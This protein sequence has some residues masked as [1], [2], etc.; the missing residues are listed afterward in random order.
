[1]GIRGILSAVLCVVLV[2]SSVMFLGSMKAQGPSTATVFTDP[3]TIQTTDLEETFIVNLNVSNVVDLYGWQAGITFNPEVL[4]CTGFFEGEFLK[5]SEQMTLFL[6]HYKDMNNTLGIVYYRGDTILGPVPGVNGSGQLAYATFRSK[7][8]GVSD[9][10]LTD[11]ILI[12]SHV[13]QILFE[14]KES[15]TVF[16]S[17]TNYDVAIVDNLT[18]QGSPAN[19]PLSGMFS[20]AFNASEKEVHFSAVSVG[21]WF[22]E[23]N[24]PKTLLSS[25][26]SSAWTVKVDGAPIS[27]TASEND[28]HTSL[29]FEHAQG[30]YVVEVIGTDVAKGLT[31]IPGLPPAVII[32]VAFLGLAGL[33]LALLDLRKTR[34]ALDYKTWNPGQIRPSRAHIF[35]ASN[36]CILWSVG[37]GCA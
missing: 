18:G 27:Y 35:F 9:F 17:G 12:N 26:V 7:R 21:A 30:S 36:Q 31:P 6:S 14:V 11:V 29:Y 34:K 16:L 19:P 37:L 23:L 22:C 32:L 33:T 15:L 8:V 25:N 10:H 28:T 13:E 24:V 4:E 3:L 5:R 2:V 20:A 1:M